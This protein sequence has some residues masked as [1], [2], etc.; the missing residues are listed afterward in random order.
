MNQQ[1]SLQTIA[2]FSVLLVAILP[3]VHSFGV[4]TLGISG[5]MSRFVSQSSCPVSQR[6]HR[7]TVSMVNDI[8]GEIKKEAEKQINPL[9]QRVEAIKF[10]GL[11][12]ELLAL[13]D[14]T[15]RGVDSPEG[16][17]PR[18][19][20][21]EII[22][23]LEK[24][25]PTPTEQ[26]LTSGDIDG[27]WVL[28]WTTSESIL[29]RK[30]TRG[31]RVDLNRPILQIINSKELTAKNVEPVTTFRWIFGGIKYTNSVEAELKVM[32]P[33]KV[34]VQFKK[35]NIAGGLIRIKAP[36]KARGELDTTYLDNAE[37]A[38]NVSERIRISR[39]DRGNVFVLTKAT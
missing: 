22:E 1:Y 32:T 16:S 21:M 15:L 20:I 37:S 38:S 8:P 12:A 34:A 27:E 9:R 36:E 3:S 23:Q 24:Q 5:R 26:V 14:N 2:L 33:S 7:P 39:G 30:R 35:F 19:R 6:I 17:E 28:R 4:Q 10:E 11:R 18:Q 31:F 13:S 29:G 25:N